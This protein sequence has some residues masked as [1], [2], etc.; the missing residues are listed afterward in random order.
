LETRGDAYHTHPALAIKARNDAI[1]TNTGTSSIHQA[2]AAAGKLQQLNDYSCG[3]ETMMSKWYGGLACLNR[4]I[5]LIL[6]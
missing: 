1:A 6:W 4:V 3:Y 2:D 5:A